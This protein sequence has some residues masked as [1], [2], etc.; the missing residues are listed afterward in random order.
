MEWLTDHDHTQS[1]SVTTVY[2]NI[3]VCLSACTAN[4]AF[5]LQTQQ[6]VNER[7]HFLYEEKCQEVSGLQ[8]S[9]KQLAK[10]CS[11]WYQDRYCLF[12]LHKT[13]L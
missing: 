13:L 10:V 1:S 5:L 2:C 6:R 8:A 9:I 7:I 3:V 11:N 12:A 4:L